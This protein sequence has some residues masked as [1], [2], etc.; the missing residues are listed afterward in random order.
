MVG[1]R[2]SVTE[3]L[4]PDILDSMLKEVAG[5]SAASTKQLQRLAELAVEER[6]PQSQSGKPPSQ[7]RSTSTCALS[8]PP[9]RLCWST[10]WGLHRTF[11]R[12]ASLLKQELDVVLTKR[13][14]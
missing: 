10:A 14:A 7:C 2:L 12:L 9:S 1:A 13:Q 3:E 8:S 11:A 5:V 4:M 6:S